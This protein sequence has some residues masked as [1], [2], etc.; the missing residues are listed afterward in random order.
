MQKV[1]ADIHIKRML[2]ERAFFHDNRMLAERAFYCL[3][4]LYGAQCQKMAEDW[5]RCNSRKKA[6]GVIGGAG[7]VGCEVPACAKWDWQQFFYG[8]HRKY[9]ADAVQSEWGRFFEEHL[10]RD[11]MRSAARWGKNIDHTFCS[12]KDAQRVEGSYSAFAAWR[13]RIKAE[14]SRRMRQILE[15]QEHLVIKQGRSLRSFMG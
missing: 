15:N 8:K 12:V 5:L 13:R 3:G 4:M 9:C 1:S 6:D 10:V 11:W 7:H 14:Y 2:A